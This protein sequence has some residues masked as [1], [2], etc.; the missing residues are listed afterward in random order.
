[1]LSPSVAPHT[2]QEE[3][4]RL[5]S[6]ERHNEPRS[7]NKLVLWGTVIPP[8]FYPVWWGQS[9]KILQ[10]QRWRLVPWLVCVCVEV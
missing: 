4:H 7:E 2:Y 6:A 1:M 5:P 8:F 9:N 3:N 10:L